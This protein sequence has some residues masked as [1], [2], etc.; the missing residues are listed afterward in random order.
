MLSFCRTL[1]VACD[2]A[3]RELVPLLPQARL[4]PGPERKPK[5]RVWCLNVP[6]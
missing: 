2:R 6:K 4:Q 1:R 3:A 5:A